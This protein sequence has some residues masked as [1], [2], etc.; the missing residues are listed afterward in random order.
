M[1]PLQVLGVS[2]VV[3]ASVVI[4]ARPRRRAEPGNDTAATAQS[5]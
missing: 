3:L 2:L 4:M 5:D 1:E